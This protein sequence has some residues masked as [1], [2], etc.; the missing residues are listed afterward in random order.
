MRNY[1][2]VLEKLQI[3]NKNMSNWNIKSDN[4]VLSRILLF[5][6]CFDILWCMYAVPKTRIWKNIK[7]KK[8]FKKSINS[9]QTLTQNHTSLLKTRTVFGFICCN[10]Y[11]KDRCIFPQVS[12]I[13]IIFVWSGGT[14]KHQINHCCQKHCCTHDAHSFTGDFV[15]VN[16]LRTKDDLKKSFIE[17]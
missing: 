1:M 6:M 12:E 15:C 13:Y 11:F 5:K 14:W 8:S 4:N 10:Y 7:E 3:G 16:F 9:Q 2:L 17:Q